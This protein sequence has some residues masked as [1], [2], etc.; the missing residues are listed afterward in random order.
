MTLVLETDINEDNSN[1]MMLT[2]MWQ[3]GEKWLC[4]GMFLMLLSR[5][6]LPMR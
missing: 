5:F 4:L 3:G 2:V 1:S 6:T